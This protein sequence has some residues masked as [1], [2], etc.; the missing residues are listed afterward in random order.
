VSVL[1]VELNK[2][3]LYLLL[4]ERHHQQQVQ[5][6]ILMQVPLEIQIQLVEV[7]EEAVLVVQQLALQLLQP[8]QQGQT[9][10]ILQ[11]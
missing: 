4:A 8:E 11:L 9:E 7:Q 5:Y 3:V 2:E 6:I 10:Y 1:V